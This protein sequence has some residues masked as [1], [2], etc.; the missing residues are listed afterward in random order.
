MERTEDRRQRLSCTAYARPRVRGI[1]ERQCRN[2]SLKYVIGRATCKLSE[3]KADHA[4]TSGACCIQLRGTSALPC[5]K[6]GLRYQ[7]SAVL[8]QTGGGVA[9]GQRVA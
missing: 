5:S 9:A 8:S 2:T 7:R 1:D 6:R 3:F 4:A